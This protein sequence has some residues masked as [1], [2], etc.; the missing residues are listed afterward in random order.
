MS[1]ITLRNVCKS[2]DKEHYA[3][4]DFNLDIHDG[5]F[6]IF[7]GPSGCG[8][9][10]TLRMI[11]G[12]E[13]IT[14]GELW[15]DKQLCNYIEPKD[16]DLSMVFQNYALYPQMTVY[17]NMAFALQIRKVPKQEIN[18]KVH[19]AAAILGIEQL[20]KRRPGQLSGGQKQRVAIGSAIMRR[21]KA[22]LMDEPLSNLDAKLRAQMRDRKSTRL[23]S[24]HGW[25]SRMPSSA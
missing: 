1:E 4:K 14:G 13:E 6:V 12:L 18:Q 7:V 2:Y 25:T 9:S 21:P 16:R 11:A 3:V 17:D 23:N 24:S 5:E 15:I 19:E 22:F 10:T 20:L 8:K